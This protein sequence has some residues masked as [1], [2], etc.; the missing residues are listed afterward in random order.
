MILPR[1]DDEP[2]SLLLHGGAFQ[3]LETLLVHEKM[4]RK[5]ARRLRHP[6]LEQVGIPAAESRMGAF[7]HQLRA[8]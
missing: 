7:P 6:L 2:Q 8:A 4:D 1:T 5:A 3:L